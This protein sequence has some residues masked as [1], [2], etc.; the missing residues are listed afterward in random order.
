MFNPV[1]QAE[2]Q[3]PLP[4]LIAGLYLDSNDLTAGFG[5]Q[6]NAAHCPNSAYRHE[7][8]VPA[9]RGGGLGGNGDRWRGKIHAGKAGKLAIKVSG[10][11]AEDHQ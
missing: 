3:I 4:D 7:Q 6:L 1:I 5:T 2:E 8:A 11:P 9:L 10:N